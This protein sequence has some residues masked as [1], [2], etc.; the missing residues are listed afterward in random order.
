MSDNRNSPEKIARM[1]EAF[2]DLTAEDVEEAKAVL[3]AAGRDPDLVLQQ[4]LQR[5]NI[6]R[7]E[8]ADRNSNAKPKVQQAAEIAPITEGGAARVLLFR[9]ETGQVLMGSINEP[10]VVLSVGEVYNTFVRLLPLTSLTMEQ[11]HLSEEV[12]QVRFQKL[13]RELRLVVRTLAEYATVTGTLSG[14]PEMNL[15]IQDVRTAAQTGYLLLDHVCYPIDPDSLAFVRTFL[16]DVGADG[17]LPLNRALSWF[18]KR[19]EQPWLRFDPEQLDL[20]LILKSGR[21]AD[22]S[23]LFIRE[24]YKYQ[25][26][27]LQW[28][29]YCCINRIGGILGDD[30]GLGK[31]AQTIALIAWLIENKILR[32]ILVVVPSTLLEN[33][34]REFAFFAPSLLPRIYTHHGAGRTGSPTVLRSQFI[35]LTSYS[36]VVN[37]Q[38]L[39]DKVDW[40]LMLLDEASLIK[41]PDATRRQALSGIPADVRIAMSGTPVENSLLDLWSLADFANPGHLGSRAD[42]SARYIRREVRDTLA[43][44]ELPALKAEVSRVML[45]RRKEDVL[46]SLPAKIDIHQALSMGPLEAARYEE[47]RE[48]TLADAGGRGGMQMLRLIQELRQFTT[49]PLLADRVQLAT[50]ELPELLEGSIKLQRT[51]ELLNEIRSRGEKVLIFTEYLGMIDALQRTLSVHYRS[52]VITIDGRVPIAERQQR[53]DELAAREGFAIMVLNPRTAGMGLNITA[54]N[55]VIHYTRQ[56][57]PA[58]EEQA[59]ARAYRNRQTRGVNVYYLYYA[60]TIEQVIDERLRDKSALSGE[61][62]TVTKTDAGMDRYLQALNLSPLKK[63]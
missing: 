31:T 42:F 62:I 4:G 40:G 34:R 25:E 9:S 17:H 27:G 10:G 5:L 49:H 55:H 35:V 30:M 28:L 20:D 57:N 33:W 12:R 29:Q 16:Q 24:L 45:R 52:P 56:W 48:A 51:I 47:R 23:S 3:R 26:E 32:H 60:D 41:N 63:Q 53:I 19:H 18:P 38:Y 36:I 8:V 37:D 54:A 22:R 13:S 1:L 46:D 43:S 14:R 50:A 7:T 11:L 6:V 44:L 58:L 39:F 59:T 61:V 2:S 15:L 21:Y